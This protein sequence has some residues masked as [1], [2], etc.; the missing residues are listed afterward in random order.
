MLIFSSSKWPKFNLKKKKRGKLRITYLG[1]RRRAGR[2]RR[3]RRP[4][5]SGH[6]SGSSCWRR[7][8]SEQPLCWGCSKAHSAGSACNQ[9][10]HR[11]RSRSSSAAQGCSHPACTHTTPHLP[12]HPKSR[13]SSHKKKLK[14]AI[15]ENI[16]FWSKGLSFTYFIFPF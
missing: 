10:Q 12:V 13:F 11:K 14:S 15:K 6:S 8:S 16:I 4:A 5:G 9:L 3:S 1:Q 2:C 7:R